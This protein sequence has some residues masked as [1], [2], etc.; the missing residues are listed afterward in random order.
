MD[1]GA[2]RPSPSPQHLSVE[3]GPSSLESVRER[4]AQSGA[5][6]VRGVLERERVGALARAADALYAR[7]AGVLERE[8][9]AG[10]QRGL[11][12]GCRFAPTASSVTASALDDEA[13]IDV[14]WALV[15]RGPLAELLAGVHGGPC[16]VDLDQAWLRRQFAPDRYPPGHAPHSW[17]Q[18]GALGYDFA[19]SPAPREG[20]LPLVTSWMPLVSAGRDAPGLE[21][22]VTPIE[23]VLAPAELIESSVNET[24]GEALRWR[25]SMNP[26]D[27]MLMAPGTLHRT[28]VTRD[29]TETRTSVELRVFRAETRPERLRGDRFSPPFGSFDRD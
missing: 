16:S 2:S 11:P 4:L 6:L 13:G 19:A 12:S 5:V 27:V 3:A 14:V 22:I 18:D 28:H 25:P 17:H 29:M 24:Y 23:R 1:A 26:G 20:L 10:V 8:G 9:A 7:I 21:V 15:E